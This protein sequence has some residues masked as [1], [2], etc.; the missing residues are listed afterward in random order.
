MYVYT[1]YLTG[2]DNCS[3]SSSDIEKRTPFFK[4]ALSL[5]FLNE[6]GF[7][8]ATQIHV[9]DQL[10]NIEI[11]LWLADLGIIC[12]LEWMLMFRAI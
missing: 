2:G 12:E 4:S 7:W 3:L 11:A 10:Q 8:P 6:P 9:L 5:S 1:Q